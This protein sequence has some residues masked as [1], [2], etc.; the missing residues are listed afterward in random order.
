[1]ETPDIRKEDVQLPP[2]FKGKL[3]FVLYNV[4]SK[5]V[6]LIK[7]SCNGDLFGFDTYT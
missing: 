4:F 2:E 6:K 3:A 7:T 1:M 5:E